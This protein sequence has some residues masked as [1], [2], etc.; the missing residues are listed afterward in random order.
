MAY[1]EGLVRSY[2]EAGGGR[3]VEELDR[4]VRGI[5]REMGY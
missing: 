1:Y 3:L 2:R 4:I 5:R